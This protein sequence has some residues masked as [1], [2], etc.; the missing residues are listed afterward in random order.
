[1]SESF[2]NDEFSDCCPDVHVFSKHGL[3]Q[4]LACGLSKSLQTWSQAWS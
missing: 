4:L 3:A 1:M 2:E